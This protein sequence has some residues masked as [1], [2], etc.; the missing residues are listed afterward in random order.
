MIDKDDDPQIVE[1][2]ARFGRAIYMAHVLELSLAQTLMQIDFLT[3]P[4]KNSLKSKERIL[5][6]KSSMTSSMLL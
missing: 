2:F 3:Q 6:A 1:T 5:T 4:A